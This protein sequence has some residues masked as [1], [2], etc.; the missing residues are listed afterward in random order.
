V[1]NHVSNIVL[2]IQFPFVAATLEP[3]LP[4]DQS[5]AHDLAFPSFSGNI[6]PSE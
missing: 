6:S 2:I 5:L 4:Q 1:A 3:S